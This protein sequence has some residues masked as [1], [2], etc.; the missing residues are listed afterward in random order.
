MASGDAAAAPIPSDAEVD[1]KSPGSEALF[2]KLQ[3]S[4][5]I[6][7]GHVTGNGKILAGALDANPPNTAPSY[8]EDAN[9][10]F[11]TI[12][13]D[14]K[15]NQYE[16][17]FLS[18]ALTSQIYTI[19]D[20]TA[21]NDRIHVAENLF[22]LGALSGDTYEIIGH[23][24]TGR[25]SE[26]VIVGDINNFTAKASYQDDFLDC[27]PNPATPFESEAYRYDRVGSAGAQIREV[28]LF[29]NV[30][31]VLR[32]T[33]VGPNYFYQ[34][35]KNATTKQT[36]WR[37]NAP[38]LTLKA[39]LAA[40]NLPASAAMGVFAALTD[41]EDYASNGTPDA[42]NAILM[43]LHQ[44]ASNVKKAKFSVINAGTPT[45]FTSTAAWVADTMVRLEMVRT[46]ATTYD[47]YVDGVLEG[48]LTATQPTAALFI[49]PLNVT[50]AGG[51]GTPL[52]YIDYMQVVQ[53]RA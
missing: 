36:P 12:D 51:G 37:A 29:T 9:P 24:H 6:I 41:T 35:L 2:F 21:S 50:S 13:L 40:G 28:T 26:V 53:D 31:G 7:Q 52:G 22:A 45:T 34:V 11:G 49:E 3:R 19:T 48:T 30:P 38:G 18:G 20:T 1:F 15:F 8:I 25:E 17:K 43:G 42:G 16:V 14:D 27:D 5:Q 23:R 39:R 46:G 32:L 4:L 10:T 47:C 44:D 33:G